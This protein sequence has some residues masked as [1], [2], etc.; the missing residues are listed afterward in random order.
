M[1]TR[2]SDAMQTVGQRW[3][4]F[5]RSGAVNAMGIVIHSVKCVQLDSIKRKFSFV[6][7]MNVMVCGVRYVA[8]CNRPVFQFQFH[9]KWKSQ[10]KNSHSI[11]SNWKNLLI[12]A[13]NSFSFWKSY[14]LISKGISESFVWFWMHP[15]DECNWNCAFVDW[16]LISH[17]ALLTND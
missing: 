6:D 8:C 15:V 3:L 16:K 14:S 17:W 13:F 12:V 7:E 1:L 10:N 11:H 4:A 9:S 5:I 2:D